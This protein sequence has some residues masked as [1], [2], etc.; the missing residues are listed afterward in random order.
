MATIITTNILPLATPRTTESHGTLVHS[1]LSRITLFN[2]FEYKS[3]TD[4]EKAN[5]LATQK[6]GLS[7]AMPGDPHALTHTARLAT[8]EAMLQP[9]KSSFKPKESHWTPRM[10][11][12][13]SSPSTLSL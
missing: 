1:L 8:E 5:Q 4:L 7:R 9:I 3:S 6:R 12:Q 13:T 10:I 11:N 2:N